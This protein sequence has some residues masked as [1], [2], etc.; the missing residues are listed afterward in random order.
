MAILVLDSGKFF[1]LLTLFSEL[2]YLLSN[3]HRLDSQ[4]H[5]NLHKII[6]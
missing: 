3:C 4:P 5:V 1:P 2:T 6:G